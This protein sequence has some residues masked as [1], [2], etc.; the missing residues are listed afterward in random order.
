MLKES[1][2]PRTPDDVSIASLA[3]RYDRPGPRYTS[4]PTAVEFTDAF[5][6]AAYRGRLAAAATHPAEPL[7]LYVHLP[8]CAERCSYCGCSMIA[9]R[10]RDVALR[11]LPY[12][13]KELALLSDALGD[14]TRLAQL[15][16][17]GGTPTYFTSGELRGLHGA[18]QR[19]FEVDAAAECAVEIDP[20]VTTS[21]QLRT[22]R[23]LGFTRLSM[24]VQDLEADVQAAIGRHQTEHQT[25]GAYD[26]ARAAGFESINVDLV[27]GLPRQGRAGFA[28]TVQSIVGMRPDRIAVYSYAHVPWIRP[29]QKRIREPELPAPALKI[30]LIR[31]AAETFLRAGYVA[32]GMDHF[33]LPDDALA[34]AARQQRLHRNF[35]GYTTQPAR[36]VLGIGMSAIGDVCGAFSQNVKTLPA[37]YGALDRGCFP[38]ERGYALSLDDLVRRTVIT[39]LMC[40][41]HVGRETVARRHGVAFDTYFS[42][43]LDALTADGGP[44]HEGL[45]QI[46]GDGLTVTPRGRLFVRTIC[47]HFDKYLPT[48]QDQAVFSRAV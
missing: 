33:A 31:E 25:R 17:G 18:I 43:E 11:Y 23:E 24:G 42:R 6:E 2:D 45:L 34:I 36:D 5:D 32:I 40:N 1:P 19:H 41:L 48:H 16:W 3:R 4:Y 14:R 39:E 22:L 7:S 37:Y 38:V 10:N 12:L 26:V 27:Y 13:E 9:T 47:M 8:F 28:R 46:D 30:E 20:R 44:V 35:M 15:H 29:H 21:D